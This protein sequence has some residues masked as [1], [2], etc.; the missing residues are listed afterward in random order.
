MNLEIITR[1]PK[2][3]AH[4]T[5]L[6]FVHG[7]WHGAWCWDEYFLPYFADKGYL[8]RA[9][10]LRGHGKS[11]GKERLRWTSVRRYVEDVAQV[12][13][14]FANPPVVIGHSMG[15]FVVQKYLETHNAP[16][17]VLMASIP[18]HG[19]FP[20]MIRATIKHP[21]AMLKTITQID[22]YQLVGTPELTHDA[23]FSKDL[24]DEKV[25]KYF[26]GIQQESFATVLDLNVGYLP[27]PKRV[28]TPMLVLG[29]AR[30]R[31][32]TV[33]EVGATAKAYNT[34]AEIFPHTAHDMMLEINWRAIADR[35]IA[36]LQERNI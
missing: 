19:F 16:A 33:G 1:K 7:A 29:A 14:D 18:P 21:I 35:M 13:G 3:N 31:I 20:A 32:F 28:Q 30:D 9:V 25:Q 22:P 10:S 4:L 5:P 17:G 8:A 6:L 34:E 27:R 12:A 23:F 24:P 11:E 36:W 2:T 15:G 26:K